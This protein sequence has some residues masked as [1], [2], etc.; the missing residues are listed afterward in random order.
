MKKTF[1]SLCI[2]LV[3]ITVLAEQK[4]YENPMSTYHENYFIM[5]DENDQT[6]FQVS[7]KY[8]L[9]Y[10]SKVGLY[11]G[12]TQRSL[13]NTYDKSTPF[14]E[15]NYMPEMFY[16]IE[17]NNNLFDWNLVI[18]DYI[19]LSP[20]FHKSNGRDGLD[21]RGINTYYGQIQLSYG[22]VYNIGVNI[23]GFNYYTK[24][25][26]NSD[27]EDYQGYYEAD[28]FFKLRSKNVQYLDKEE[29]HVKFGSGKD[30]GWVCGE[31]SFRILTTYVQPK[32]FIQVY[33]GYGEWIIDYNKKDTTIRA[34]LVF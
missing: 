31:M 24:S 8:A 33:H 22:E 34:G 30:K 25:K 28:V 13:W 9:F 3:S 26:K 14:A 5:G 11:A 29:L 32:L 16:R 19:Q 1:I 23:K 17:N 18:I 6:K 2:I 12:Y 27:I 20:I 10:P 15:T 7:A 21:S 4:E